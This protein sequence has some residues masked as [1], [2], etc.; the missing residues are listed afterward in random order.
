MIRRFFEPNGY[1]LSGEVSWSG[2]ESGAT[3]VI[4]IAR[5]RVHPHGDQIDP[6]CPR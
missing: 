6:D 5:T 3:G 1:T 4:Y 2:H